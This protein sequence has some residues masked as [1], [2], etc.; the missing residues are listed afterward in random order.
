MSEKEVMETISKCVEIANNRMCDFL[1]GQLGSRKTISWRWFLG[2]LK[3]YFD[4]ACEKYLGE[5]LGDGS[6]DHPRALGYL[7]K[8]N[9]FLEEKDFSK[10]SIIDEG[11]LFKMPICLWLYI[12][13]GAVFGRYSDG[14]DS[15]VRWD[16]YKNSKVIVESEKVFDAQVLVG[17]KEIGLWADIEKRRASE[18]PT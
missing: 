15:G 10:K 14:G 2:W 5:Y 13:Y 8:I 4:N 7:F 6:E 11:E 1:I 17:E 3:S 16:I 9:K 18:M 12:T